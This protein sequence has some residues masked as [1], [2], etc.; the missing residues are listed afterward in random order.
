MSSPRKKTAQPVQ[1]PSGADP[2]PL[3]GPSQQV[4][5]NDDD[6]E[7]YSDYVG[8]L[9]KKRIRFANDASDISRYNWL[10]PY[11]LGVGLFLVLFPFWLLDSLKDPI[12]GSLTDNNLERHQ[13]TAK[14]F[15]VCTTLALVCFLEYFSNEKKR[16]HR[17]EKNITEQ[18]ILDGGG[19]WES[20]R[21]V[22]DTDKHAREEE[23]SD[24]AV[25]SSI[26]AIIGLPYCL[27]FG[28][29]AYLLQ[30]N[31]NVALTDGP[32]VTFGTNPQRLWGTLGY[33]FFAA[34]ESYGSLS[35]AAFWSYTNSTL[36]LEDAERFYGPVIAIAQLGAACGSTMVTTQVWN[37]VTLIVLACLIILLHILVMTSYSRRFPPSN[38]QIQES[39]VEPTT[40]PTE[41]T[42][43]SG[44]YLILRHNYVLLIFG[45][46][47]LYEISLTVL[48]YQMTLLGWRRFEETEHEN[49]SVRT[50]RLI[51]LFFVSDR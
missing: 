32:T 11:W 14:L 40:T 9:S 38:H 41:P 37:N 12:L 18:E 33:F 43:W 4:D 25:P 19:P 50:I 1:T 17:L 49:M 45:A 44:V 16:Q 5:G 31:A 28:F 47:S 26:F 15:S 46:S 3:D 20:M 34:I 42:L 13:P 36:S 23:V 27:A 10:R 21:M 29:M 30:F 35:V 39:V 22:D 8:L 6:R 24:D 2:N 7:E 48:N 51:Y